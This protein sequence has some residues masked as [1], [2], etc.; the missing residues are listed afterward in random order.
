MSLLRRPAAPRQCTQ[1]RTVTCHLRRT[2]NKQTQGTWHPH[3][4]GRFFGALTRLLTGPSGRPRTLVGTHPVAAGPLPPPGRRRGRF[5]PR[6]RRRFPLPPSRRLVASGRSRPHQL[7]AVAERVVDVS[8]PRP[9]RRRGSAAR[10]LRRSS[11]RPTARPGPGPRVPGGPCGPGGNSPPRPGA[12]PPPPG[13]PAAAPCRQGLG[14]RHP[15]RAPKGPSRTPRPPPRLRAGMASCTWSSPDDLETHG[16]ILAPGA[17]WQSASG[18]ASL[19][20]AMGSL[21]KKR[22]KR[23]RKKKHKKMLEGDPLAASR[24]E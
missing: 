1:A 20:H 23:M 15:V 19:P 13:E 6:P 22:R 3:P 4:S 10:S 2:D 17:T 16:G 11:T 18:T 8:S 12:P 24:G 9:V 14:F 21:I 5:P 7:D